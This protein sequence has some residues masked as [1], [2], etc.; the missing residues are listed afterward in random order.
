[1]VRGKIL[2]EL[3]STAVKEKVNLTS[4]APYALTVPALTFTSDVFLLMFTTLAYSGEGIKSCFIVT[5][6]G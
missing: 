3:L 5:Y 4:C 1:M 2:S 6:T